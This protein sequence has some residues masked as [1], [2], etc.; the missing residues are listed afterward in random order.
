MLGVLIY[1]FMTGSA[2]FEAPYPMQIYAKVLRLGSVFS[3]KS[4]AER[5]PKEGDQRGEVPTATVTPVCGHR[6][7]GPFQEVLEILEGYR[8][9]NSHENRLYRLYRAINEAIFGGDLPK[10]ARGPPANA[11]RR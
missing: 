8:L 11:Y 2:P 1:E 6:E 5:P 9:Y 3:S 10:R 7:G 4:L